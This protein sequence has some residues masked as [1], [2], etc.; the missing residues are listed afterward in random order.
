ME[1]HKIALRNNKKLTY[2]KQGFSKSMADNRTDSFQNEI[3]VVT[4]PFLSIHF[5]F[6]LFEEF[7]RKCGLIGIEYNTYD[8]N[9]RILSD[10]ECLLSA[11]TDSLHT[12]LAREN[13]EKAHF[14]CWCQSAKIV[15]AYY[16]LHP[17]RFKSIIGIAP[18][19][20]K[21]EWTFISKLPYNDISK[22]KKILSVLRAARKHFLNKWL[23][24]RKSRNIVKKEPQLTAFRS[25]IFNNAA[26]G[27]KY[28]HIF[29]KLVQSPE[30][31]INY[32]KMNDGMA[33]DDLTPVVR[34][35][36]VPFTILHGNQD[37]VI[38]VNEADALLFRSNIHIDYRILKGR[39]H[40]MLLDETKKIISIIISAMQS[41]CG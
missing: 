33:N 20:R 13:I 30:M 31:I 8:D 9:G 10:E 37:L 18:Y 16:N 26:N 23:L 14:F 32:F 22:V 3:I 11:Y 41:A 4:S 2:Y 27:V 34:N 39:T 28:A 7:E 19:F 21:A 24:E 25:L 29:N 38:P 5:L 12:V 15:L 36:K 1:Q 17:E 40:Y 35:I 6:S